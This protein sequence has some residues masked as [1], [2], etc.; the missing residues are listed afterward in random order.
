MIET[1]KH[2][3]RLRCPSCGHLPIFKAPFRIRQHCPSCGMVFEREDGYF[4]GAIMVNIIATEMV[5]LAIYLFCLL[6][7]GFSER[8]IFFILF[9]MGLI[10][11]AVFYHHS[12]SLWLS[13]NYL[14]DLRSWDKS[15]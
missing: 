13:F 12:W 7:I 8:F 2:C 15:F 6:T 11:P 5:I 9:P 14:I 4:V 3:A 10:S 1:L